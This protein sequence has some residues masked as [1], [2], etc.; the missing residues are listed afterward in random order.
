M[1]LY[2]EVNNDWND[3]YIE[4][5]ENYPCSCRD[6]L[7][8]REGEVIRLIGTL[9]KAIAGRSDKEYYNDNIE[10]IKA[11][12]IENADKI[13]EERKKYNTKNAD[14]IKE[15]MKEHRIENNDAIKEKIKKYRIENADNIKKNLKEKIMCECGCQ[16]NKGNILRHKET[17]NHINLL[18]SQ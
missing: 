6:E 14:K 1:K 3:W 7:D 2:Q 8:K 18:G 10:K 13:K 16:I 9:N 4:L 15:Y 5:Y 11:Y 12:L 17:P